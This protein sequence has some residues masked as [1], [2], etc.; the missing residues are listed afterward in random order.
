MWLTVVG[1]LLTIFA[2]GI[3][4]FVWVYKTDFD[5]EIGYLK[6][7]IENEINEIKQIKQKAKTDTDEITNIKLSALNAEKA[8]GLTPNEKAELKK[9]IRK[10]S[11][12]TEVDRKKVIAYELQTEGKIM[13]SIDKWLE[14]EKI[15]R[16]NNDL[17]LLQ[18]AYH[19]L[20]YLFFS[21]E[22]FE[23]A[24]KYCSDVIVISPQFAEAYNGRGRSYSARGQ[25][26]KAIDD[27]NQ[28]IRLKPNF[29]EAYSGRGYIYM[30]KGKIN[31]ALDDF[32]Q[33]I[34]LDMQD[35]FP[36]N[37]RGL[38]YARKK[39]LNQAIKDY[40]K[41]IKINP[42]FVEAYNNRGDAYQKQ[43]KKSLAKKD[44]LKAKKLDNKKKIDK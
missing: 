14:L 16:N 12:S 38:V 31:K 37:G 43:G 28:A 29:A 21:Y 35:Y 10:N 17:L 44:F 9:Q 25:L 33:A 3:P 42:K 34:K 32:N 41:A 11:N 4:F 13:Q 23:K 20:G 5:K 8:V 18:T 40:S 15:A 19:S 26:S 6:K 36:Y 2:V 24:I 1:I 39:E 27:F 22:N 30:V 7:D